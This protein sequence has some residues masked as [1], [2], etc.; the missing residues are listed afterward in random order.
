MA[1]VFMYAD[2]TGNL[3][4]D[5]THKAGATSY[6]GF[7]TAIFNG[8]HGDALWSGLRLRAAI[9]QGED[10]SSGVNLPRGF[11]ARNDSNRTRAQM[12]AEI[13]REAPRFDATFLRKASAYEYVKRRGEMYLY[14]YAWFEHFKRVAPLVSSELDTL[15]VIVA[16]LGTKARQTQ[17][18]SALKDVCDQMKRSFVL[19]TWDS[20][21]SWGLQVADYGLWAINRQLDG[22]SGTWYLDYVKPTVGSIICPWGQDR[23]VAW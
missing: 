19:C 9:E 12:F 10:S 4:Y 15:F 3:D 6:F 22:G 1:D 18:S 20:A 11:H 16:S 17:A 13:A 7:G 23:G 21:S 14:K 5:A 2:E 8:V